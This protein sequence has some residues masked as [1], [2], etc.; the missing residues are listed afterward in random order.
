[1]ATKPQM[2]GP[3]LLPCLVDEPDLT[4]WKI[5]VC[6]C[7]M[8]PACRATPP[9]PPHKGRASPSRCFLN[10]ENCPALC[11]SGYLEEPI[12]WGQPRETPDSCCRKGKITLPGCL[13]NDKGGV[14]GKGREIVLETCSS[15]LQFNICFHGNRRRVAGIP[16]SY[17]NEPNSNIL[18]PFF[19]TCIALG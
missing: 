15:F 1:M 17:T 8:E 3:R 11:P 6:V 2:L 19:L 5:T 13:G 14:G 7:R 4:G 9:Q 12:G 18:F 10:G 16:V